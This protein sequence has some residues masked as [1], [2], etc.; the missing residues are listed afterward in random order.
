[1]PRRF[2]SATRPT[3]SILAITMAALTIVSV[4]ACSTIGG[5][6]PSPAGSRALIVHPTG[7]LDV[8]LR[9]EQGGGFVP[10]EF[11]AAEAPAF[12]LYGNG[13]IVFQR[14]SASFPR[15]DVNGAIRGTPWRIAS[16]DEAGIQDLLAF[17]LG[18]AGLGTAR[19]AYPSTSVADAPDTIFTIRAGGIARRIVVNAL[20]EETRPSADTTARAAFLRLAARIRAFDQDGTIPSDTFHPDRFRGALTNRGEAMGVMPDVTPIAWPWPTLTPA[21]FTTGGGDAT[22]GR[23]LPRRVMTAEEVSALKLPGIEGGIQGLTI[24]GPDGK[25]YAFVLR[26]LLPDERQ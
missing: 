18:S 23:S 4:S 20:S 24:R 26:P 25:T 19:D 6:T 12:T 8:V 10:I 14:A 2:L 21:A 22:N 13:S 11:L 17:A 9:L 7:P 16:L 3:R 5:S 15:P 1:M